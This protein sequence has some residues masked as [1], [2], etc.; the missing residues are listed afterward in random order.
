[1]VSGSVLIGVANSCS[2][3]LHKFKQTM[4]KDQLGQFELA[5]ASRG[6][7]GGLV[8]LNQRVKH[9]CTVMY[10]LN[11]D[12]LEMVELVDKLHDPATAVPA[13][14]PLSQ[15]FCQI[16]LQDGQLSTSD[17]AGDSRLNGKTYQG[18]IKSYVGLP[19]SRSAGTLFGT[20]CHYDFDEQTIDDDE[21]QFLQQAAVV[22]AKA[23]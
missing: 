17:S 10:S 1:M 11:G 9:R 16:T 6:L 15:S 8:F 19:L 13:P 20:L 5:V 22:L 2:P 21:F 12:K 7:R 4:I 14:I 3:T 23:I 18:V